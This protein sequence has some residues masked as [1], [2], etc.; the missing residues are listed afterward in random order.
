VKL[1]L[2]NYHYQASL[3]IYEAYSFLPC[4]SQLNQ[5]YRIM[6]LRIPQVAGIVTTP[7]WTLRYGLRTRQSQ[8]LSGEFVPL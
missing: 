8:T 1:H 6:P 3:V 2:T 5:H 4:S 7:P